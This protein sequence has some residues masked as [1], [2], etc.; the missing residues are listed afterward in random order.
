MSILREAGFELDVRETGA[1]TPSAADLARAAIDERSDAVIVA[2]GDGT[3]QPVARRVAGSPVVLG[4]LP[5]GNYMN[6]AHGLGLPL[7]PLAAARVIAAKHVLRADVG[8]IGEKVFLETA[9]IGIDAEIFGA[10]R[11]AERGKWRPALRRLWRGITQDSHRVSVIVDGT[12]HRHRVWQIL[13]ANSAYYLWSLEA[14][15]ESRMDDGLLDVAVYSRMGLGE[16]LRALL[17]LV[18][19]EAYSRAPLTYRGKEVEL[20]SR[21]PLAVHADGTAVGNT[22]VTVSCRKGA[23]RVYAPAS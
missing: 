9:G 20:R 1:E 6:V 10:A 17:D 21:R 14:F 13:V 19:A 8:V 2:G 3:V 11:L 23:L 7:E 4:I 18:R 22:P 12:E 15:P 16:L 5:F